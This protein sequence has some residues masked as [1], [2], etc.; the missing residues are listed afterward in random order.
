MDLLFYQ[1]CLVSGYIY[2][3]PVQ[4]LKNNN[5]WLKNFTQ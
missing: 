5:L 1:L 3:N 2:L 4:L